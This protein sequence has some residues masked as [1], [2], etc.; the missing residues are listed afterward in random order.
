MRKYL[1]RFANNKN[2]WK[3][4]FIDFHDRKSWIFLRDSSK[5]LCSASA[6]YW[7]GFTAF[8]RIFF[9][10]SFEFELITRFRVGLYF[11]F[12]RDSHSLR[13]FTDRT[14]FSQG[15]YKSWTVLDI[16]GMNR[17]YFEK[18]IR[19]Y[20]NV[21]RGSFFLIA[22]PLNGVLCIYFS[23]KSDGSIGKSIVF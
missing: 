22:V 5:V 2:R 12:R 16:I 15:R 9:R 10:G 4:Y 19:K 13:I 23:Y 18:I 20:C 6:N 11:Y 1:D 8:L 3:L 7:Y 14:D 21:Y 17:F